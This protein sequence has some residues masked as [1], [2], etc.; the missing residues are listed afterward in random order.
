MKSNDIIKHVLVFA[1]LVTGALFVAS[2]KSGSAVPDNDLNLIDGAMIPAGSV[3]PHPL[4]LP[5]GT[6]LRGGYVLPDGTYHG[7][8]VI[9]A[10][11]ELP[12]GTVLLGNAVIP[13]GSLMPDDTLLPGGRQ[14]GTFEAT[15]AAAGLFVPAGVSFSEDTGLSGGSIVAGSLSPTDADLTFP[16][17]TVFSSSYTL[18]DGSVVPEGTTLPYTLDSEVTLPA[19]TIIIGGA[20]IPDGETMTLPAGTPLAGPV[21]LS[22]D[23][24]ISASGMTVPAGVVVSSGIHIPQG[25]YFPNGL[26]LPDGSALY[27]GW[28]DGGVTLRPADASTAGFDATAGSITIGEIIIPDSTAP[29]AADL[30]LPPGSAFDL[31]G[32]PKNTMPMG[33]FIAPAASFDAT[34]AGQASIDL[35]EYTLFTGSGNVL[36]GDITFPAGTVFHGGY[37]SAAS[38]STVAPFTADEDLTLSA[39][40]KLIGGAA[41]P[42]ASGG[43]LTIEIS[44]GFSFPGGIVIPGCYEQPSFTEAVGMYLPEGT[45]SES[46]IDFATG[47][48]IDADA[49]VASGIIVAPGDKYYV[50]VELGSPLAAATALNAT[51]TWNTS[52]PAT[53]EIRYSKIISDS[54]N[55]AWDTCLDTTDAVVSTVG[56]GC[57]KG[58]ESADCGVTHSL[59]IPELDPDTRYYFRIYIG[60]A[61]QCGTSTNESSVLTFVTAPLCSDGFALVTVSDEESLVLG[62]FGQTTAM[63]S[64]AD[65]KGRLYLGASIEQHFYMYKTDT[66]YGTVTTQGITLDNENFNEIWDMETA[67]L[68]GEEYLFSIYSGM[69]QN[70]MLYYSKG[71]LVGTDL[72]L[73]GISYDTGSGS[74][75]PP[76]RQGF[77]CGS[78]N[79]HYAKVLYG[80]N[81]YIYVGTSFNDTAR[82]Y[83]ATTLAVDATTTLVAYNFADD[84]AEGDIFWSK[85]GTVGTRLSAIAEYNDRLYVSVKN[86]SGAK[87]FSTP[88]ADRKDPVWS[89][90]ATFAGNTDIPALVAAEDG[91]RL[92]IGTENSSGA[93]LWTYD[94]T[95]GFVKIVNFGDGT[96]L[97]PGAGDATSA[98]S[99][100]ISINFIAE[101]GPVNRYIYFGTGKPS[102]GFEVWRSASAMTAPF[103]QMGSTD[104][105]DCAVSGSADSFGSSAVFINARR[106]RSIGIGTGPTAVDR[107]FISVQTV[108]PG[109]IDGNVRVYRIDD[110]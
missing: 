89:Q 86:A 10:E 80:G 77:G 104:T 5:V 29:L 94:A 57:I 37:Y 33:A 41:L 76:S 53:E 103:T 13:A 51:V 54:T 90:D 44:S 27:R 107:L 3:L 26:I 98:D 9:T 61:G 2:C 87:I 36:T 1:L 50:P 92:F 52:A 46:G 47:T 75:I 95:T 38:L 105:G 72:E 67:V 42:D 56:V 49:T 48:D 81:G 17:G 20:V 40:D 68:D 85:V 7:P 16:A 79:Q 22:L 66:A 31:T 99:T 8:V 25:S 23:F 91:S 63:A 4:A 34:T 18:P 24:T 39:G 32:T 45:Y 74:N 65:F 15:L 83:A 60:G 73:I 82:L 88:V 109:D 43:I 30:F 102:A 55:A 12:E 35:P 96:G 84:D 78:I 11:F 28:I 14:Y 62:N 110:N 70:F 6:A 59:D 58:C 108:P 69:T 71:E 93:E 101:N 100:N 106:A 97:A 19:G 64:L 21:I